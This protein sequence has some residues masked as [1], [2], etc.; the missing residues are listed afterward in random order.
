MKENA[1]LNFHKAEEKTLQKIKLCLPGISTQMA[2]G[3]AR[4]V[5]SQ[6]YIYLIQLVWNKAS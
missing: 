1:N 4:K 5:S 6:N 2:G 3:G